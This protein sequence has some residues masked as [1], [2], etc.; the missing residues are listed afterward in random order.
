MTCPIKHTLDIIGGKWKLFI[1]LQL[2]GSEQLRFSQLSKNIPGIT[3]TVLSGCLRGYG[4]RRHY[5][6]SPVQ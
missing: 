6:S 1:V 2:F 4:E 3:N 5:S